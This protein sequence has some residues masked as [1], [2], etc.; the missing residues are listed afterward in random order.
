MPNAARRKTRRKVNP[1]A[2]VILVALIL[3]AIAGIIAYSVGYRYISDSGVKFSGTVKNGQP[4][5]GTVKYADGTSG[6]LKK[7]ADSPYGT[8]V[9][10]T[11][12]V[13]E[14]AISGILRSG[15]G[16][17]TYKESGAVYEGDFLDDKLT[18]NASVTSDD[19]YSYVGSVVDGK[20]DG[21]GKFVFPDG[22]YYYG[23]WSNDKKNGKGEYHYA[24]GAVYYGTYVDDKRS[25]SEIVTVQLENGMLYTGKCR[26]TFANGDEYVG[27][28]VNDRRTGKGTYKFATGDVYEGDFV[29]GVMNGY[30]TYRFG[31]GGTPYTGYFENGQI[32]ESD[33]TLP[34]TA[35]DENTGENNG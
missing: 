2:L 10:N 3:I 27:D 16:K 5:S 12:D 17:I 28:F 4:V 20:K 22:S 25:G 8:I 31:A 26:Q 21:V 24:S 23:E 30:G 19:G 18:G 13:Y 29:D 32:K 34:E 14:G 7:D 15:K 9:Y 33:S 1:F 11:G 6:K 35:A